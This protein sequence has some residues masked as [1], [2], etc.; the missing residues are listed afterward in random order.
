[1]APLVAHSTAAQQ[2]IVHKKIA[3]RQP[4]R[5]RSPKISLAKNK[6]ASRE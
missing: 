5:N 4:R 3:R 1:M 2:N 6:K